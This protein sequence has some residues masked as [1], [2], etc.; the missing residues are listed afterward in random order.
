M[1]AAGGVCGV[2]REEM[3]EPSAGVRVA[4]RYLPE[5]GGGGQDGRTRALCRSRR[6]VEVLG[7]GPAGEGAAGCE[8]QTAVM[9]GKGEEPEAL[10][11]QRVLRA[12]PWE[13]ATRA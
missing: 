12:G 6:T 4:E 11:H 5:G 9:R 3:G 8:G 1:S 13:A 10:G 7:E 2:W